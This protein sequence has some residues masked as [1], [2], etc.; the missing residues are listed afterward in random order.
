MPYDIRKFKTGFKVCKKG[1][2]KCFSNEPIPFGRA[3][4]Q[5]K[6]IGMSGGSLKD[7][8]EGY[9]DE[10]KQIEEDPLDDAELKQLLGNPRILKYDQ[11]KDYSS[12]EQLLPKRKD[13]VILLYL[14]APNRGHWTAVIRDDNKVYFFCSYGSQVDEPLSWVDC[15]TRMK[16]GVAVPF[17]TRL[18]NNDE[19]FDKYYSPAKYQND[20]DTDI[21]TCGRYIVLLLKEM[22]KNP[23]YNMEDFYKY[24]TKIKNKFKLTYDEVVA[25][26]IDINN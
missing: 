6:A 18:F 20:D 8:L 19:K 2:K 11:L 1:S 26:L 17:L 21:N 15:Q 9:G 25:T 23:N 14:D 3:K 5:L 4:K 16:L 24:L 22:K 7:K 10:V 12:L 13:Y